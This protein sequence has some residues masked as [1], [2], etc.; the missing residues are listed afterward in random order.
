MRYVLPSFSFV[1]IWLGKISGVFAKKYLTRDWQK[2]YLAR[3]PV[4]AGRRK[5]FF[6][7]PFGRAKV[8]MLRTG[9]VL[10]VGWL[11]TSSLWIYPHSLSYFNEAIGGPLN[12]PKHLLGSNVDWGQDLRYL[13]WWRM[14]S[15][16]TRQLVISYL[17]YFEPSKVVA[18][19]N[20]FAKLSLSDYFDLK[21]SSVVLRSL[22]DIKSKE[23]D[24]HHSNDHRYNFAVSANILNGNFV[25]G[26]D[27]GSPGV[28]I[29]KQHLEKI[30]SIALVRLMMGG[31]LMFIQIRP[32]P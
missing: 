25:V 29:A 30:R 16:D 9:V 21:S 13:V 24:G 23:H 15:T 27:G 26:R 19:G 28:P 17:G 20:L 10:L 5:A 18:E 4:W 12:G 6:L 22:H 8:K 11:V 2:E 7:A 3:R 1:F 31:G 32:N 14:G